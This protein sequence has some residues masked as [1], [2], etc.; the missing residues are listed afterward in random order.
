MKLALTCEAHG[1]FEGATHAL[2]AVLDE[3]AEELGWG[4]EHL[5]AQL[6]LV[7][8]AFL[9]KKSV[10]V[11]Q[12]GTQAPH[13]LASPCPQLRSTIL[14]GATM[15]RPTKSRFIPTVYRP[16]QPGSTP[17]TLDQ[18]HC[19]NFCQCLSKARGYVTCST[20]GTSTSGWVMPGSSSWKRKFNSLGL[21]LIPRHRDKV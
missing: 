14:L 15:L 5:V 21:Y 18:Y 11:R 1:A 8:D 19:C 6:T 16:Q 12:G 17:A 4:V 20:A 7:V 2:E 13:P 3:V 9:C 10:W